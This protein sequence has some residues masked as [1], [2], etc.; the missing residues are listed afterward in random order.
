[1]KFGIVKPLEEKHIT[2][3]KKRPSIPPQIEIS[4]FATLV[5]TEVTAALSQGNNGQFLVVAGDTVEIRVPRINTN[6]IVFSVGFNAIVGDT[7]L[8]SQSLIQGALPSSADLTGVVT[9]IV[10][11]VGNPGYHTFTLDVTSILANL[12]TT[13]TTFDGNNIDTGLTMNAV[14][15]SELSGSL[16]SE[17]LVRFG[18]RWKYEDGEYSA[19]SPFT[20]V[21]F[22]AGTFSFHPTKDTF[23]LGMLNN[24]NLIIFKCFERF[25]TFVKN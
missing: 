16:F 11:T 8:L 22:N 1:M 4:K 15:R 17:R 9:N 3:V 18:T 13:V 2:V 23:N 19:F 20:E 24:S 5:P 6:G 7:V 10:Q 25:S 12:P 14:V 21:A